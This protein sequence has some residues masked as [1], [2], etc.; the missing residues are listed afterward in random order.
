MHLVPITHIVYTYIFQMR[1]YN[2]LYKFYHI[3]LYVICIGIYCRVIRI[4]R[5]PNAILR[6]LK[7]I[8]NF[9][10]GGH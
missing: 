9:K 6:N 1:N 4:H 5:E 10:I 8:S 2:K 3:K 7:R